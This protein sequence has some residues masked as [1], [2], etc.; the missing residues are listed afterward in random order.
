MQKTQEFVE[1]IKETRL[2]KARNEQL[3]FLWNDFLGAVE[4]LS[5][6][7]QKKSLLQHFG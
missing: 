2:N 1:K 4:K 6:Y 7:F 3:D 5:M